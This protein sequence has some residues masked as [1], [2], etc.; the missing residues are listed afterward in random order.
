MN[1]EGSDK[2]IIDMNVSGGAVLINNKRVAE[3]LD[4]GQKVKGKVDKAKH[5]FT[6]NKAKVNQHA[7]E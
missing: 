6:L 2:N 5:T 1:Y 3:F 4:N 7:E